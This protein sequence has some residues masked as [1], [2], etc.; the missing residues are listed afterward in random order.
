V[1]RRLDGQLAPDGEAALV[2]V[3]DAITAH[4]A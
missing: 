3:L 4:D 1:Y 2:A